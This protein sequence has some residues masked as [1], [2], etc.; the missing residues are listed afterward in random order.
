MIEAGPE[1]DKYIAELRGEKC[2]RLFIEDDPCNQD[3]KLFW[4]NRCPLP[5][6]YECKNWSTNRND[7]W[8]LWDE[9]KE[10]LRQVELIYAPANFICVLY[11]YEWKSIYFDG[12]DEAD[13]ISGAYI[14]YMEA[15]G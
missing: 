3:C 12:K 14:K 11:S 7:A 4:D 10:N 9:M 6:D 13:A 8:E 5:N 2:T 1:R 15:K